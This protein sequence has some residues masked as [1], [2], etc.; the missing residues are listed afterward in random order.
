MLLTLSFECRTCSFPLSL[1]DDVEGLP[2]GDAIRGGGEDG[3]G[4]G[5]SET[6]KFNTSRGDLETGMGGLEA[7]ADTGDCVT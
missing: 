2:L 3:G 4:P 1:D 6:G 5:G 7:N